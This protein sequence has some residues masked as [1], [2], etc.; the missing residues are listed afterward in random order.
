[1]TTTLTPPL[2]WPGGKHYLARRIVA[3]MPPHAHFVEP[4]A[5]GLAVLLA[6]SP[7]GISECVNDLNAD[8]T[9]LWRVLQHPQRFERFQRVLEAVPFSETEWT[10]A[11]EKLSNTTG[12]VGRAGRFFVACRQSLAG[13][14]DSFAPLSRTRT[15][16]GMNEQCSAWLSAI[17]GLPQVH[18]RLRRVAVLNRPALEVIQGQDGPGTLFYVDPP[19]LP[20][21]RTATDTYG[22]FEMTKRDHRELLDLLRSIKGKVMLSGYRSRPYDHCLADWNRYEFELPNNAARGVTKRRMNEVVWTNF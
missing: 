8:L 14:M 18:A 20:S 16:R 3:L 5:G 17:D 21:T 13:R 11:T 9:N 4:F 12:A 19:Y 6:K 1:M 15:R 22:R 7:E 10:D 2:N